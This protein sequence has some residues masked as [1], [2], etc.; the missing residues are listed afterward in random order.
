MSL[1]NTTE[2]EVLPV[3]RPE[4]DERDGICTVA[5]M[6]VKAVNESGTAKG[7]VVGSVARN[8][9]ISGDRDI[10]VFML[11]PPEL[12][13]ELLEEEGIVLGRS[14]A[15]EP[16]SLI[17]SIGPLTLDQARKEG[18]K[19]GLFRPKTLFP[20]PE[21]ELK[22]LA[23]KGCTFVSVEMSNGQMIDDIRLAIRCSQPVELVNRMGG[24]LI[25]LDQIMDK[26]R[27]VAGE[28]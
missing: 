17:I 2:E 5:E 28:A 6:L 1:R 14:I 18:F 24:N 21:A 9:W 20:F 25:T 8:T 7:M 27:K 4:K 26:I 23:E 12:P 3:I 16:S 15:A 13:R 11:Y 10:D 22:A 19:V